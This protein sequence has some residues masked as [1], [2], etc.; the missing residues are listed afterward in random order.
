MGRSSL[1]HG[2]EFYDIDSAGEKASDFDEVPSNPGETYLTAVRSISIA[3]PTGTT[4]SPAALVVNGSV[5]AG[6]ET[7]NIDITPLGQAQINLA[8]GAVAGRE[9]D[10][11][12]PIVDAINGA[13]LNASAAGRRIEILAVDAA[14]PITIDAASITT[15]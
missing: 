14:E 4:F 5:Y 8:V 6:T 9:F 1:R 13:G 15:V 7:F 12:Q 2:R 11:I 10:Q 3:E